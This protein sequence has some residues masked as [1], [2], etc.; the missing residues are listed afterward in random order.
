MTLISVALLLLTLI[1]TVGGGL[2]AVIY[3][4]VM[5]VSQI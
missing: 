1:C 2:A 5:Q 4:D 3:I